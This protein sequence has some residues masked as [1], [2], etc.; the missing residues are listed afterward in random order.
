MNQDLKN[1]YQFFY[2]LK[3]SNRA[4]MR[5]LHGNNWFA[6]YQLADYRTTYV[7]TIEI[8]DK[9]IKTGVAAK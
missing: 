2:S 6:D 1:I 3:I 4:P 7:F 9:Q 5:Q 8:F